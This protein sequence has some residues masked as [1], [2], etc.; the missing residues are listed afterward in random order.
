MFVGH[1]ISKTG[2]GAWA[3]FQRMLFNNDLEYTN[4]DE[5]V[6]QEGTKL[7]RIPQLII[8]AD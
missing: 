7:K 8:Y 6:N 3:G 1:T 4:R 5:G 2:G